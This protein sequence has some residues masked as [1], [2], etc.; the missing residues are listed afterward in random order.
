MSGVI[1]VAG[2]LALRPNRGG[3]TWVFLQYLLGLRRL[4]WDV[5]FVDHVDMADCTDELGRPSGFEGSCQRAYFRR[6]MGG[7]GLDQASALLSDDGSSE[8]LSREDVI[9]L[10]R[11]SS[12]LVNVMGFLRDEAVLEAAP[13]RVFLDIDPGFPQM[14]R[15][16]GLADVMT[17]HDDFVTI[18]QNIGQPDCPIP[19]CGLDWLTT[20]Q[21]VVLDQWPVS[22]GAGQ[23][24]T[25]I[26]TW[27]GAYGPVEYRGRTYGQRVHEFRRFMVLP[28]L[29]GTTFELAFDIHPSERADL[30][31]LAASGWSLSD[32]K[33]VAGDPWSYRAFIQGSRAEFM[34]AKGMYVGTQ[35]GWFSDRSIC[36]LASGKPVVAQDTGIRELLPMGEGILPFT[37]LEEAC[38]AIGEIK[39]DYQRHGRAARKLAEEYFDSDRVLGDLLSALGVG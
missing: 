35:S 39:D 24:V 9:S 29:T 32:P 13:R 33:A 14:W 2:A 5:V 16:L 21:P 23:R 12:L 7:F 30:V 3:H 27:R 26:G 37:S 38:S 18:G 17:G 15:D 6:V 19:T 22:E 36:Y 20:R 28:L 11:D 1:V 25:S 4:G 8:G 10:T 31:S 34:V